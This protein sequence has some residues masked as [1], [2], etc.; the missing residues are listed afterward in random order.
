MEEIESFNTLDPAELEHVKYIVDKVKGKEQRKSFKP[1]RTTK[2]NVHDPEKEKQRESKKDKHWEITAAT[3]PL[4]V[5]GAAKT[6]DLNE[7]LRLLKEQNIKLQVIL[8]ST[9][10][11]IFPSL[12]NCFIF[13]CIFIDFRKFKQ[14]ML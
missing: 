2:S 9:I 14:S 5:H 6:V 10:H 11:A 4:I 7:S 3:P 1:Y 8:T 13:N 12:V